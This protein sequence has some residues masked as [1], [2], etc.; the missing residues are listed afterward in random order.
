MYGFVVTTHHNNYELISKCLELLFKNSPLGSHIILYVN[1]TTCPKILN[2]KNEYS[3]NGIINLES[4]EINE[5][6]DESSVLHFEVVYIDNQKRNGGLTGTWN[7]GINYLLNKEC[8]VITLLGHDSFVN[9]SIN[10]MLDLAKK[11][12]LS[13][14][15]KYFGPLCRS[16]KHTG[17]NLWQDSE[18]YTKHKCKYLTGF[19]MTFP[20]NSLLKNVIMRRVSIT[21]KS[22]SGSTENVSTESGS[23]E[24]VS[25][26]SGSTESGSTESGSTESD[27]TFINREFFDAIRFPFAGNE[28]E[29]Y[30]R[31]SKL[32]GEAV[33]CNK[34]IIDHEHARSWIK[35]EEEKNKSDIDNDTYVF[36]RLKIEE[37]DFN[38]ISYVRNNRDVV[39]LKT[40]RLALNHYMSI[41]KHQNRK[42]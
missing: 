29:W 21:R 5:S 26:E 30:T 18:Q 7:Q 19:Y 9:D 3:T 13:S 40:E 39:G 24:N 16:T 8:K 33:I 20:V 23:T 15:L 17:I 6:Y 42:Y 12:Y 27:S 2:I 35:V 11:A 1:E 10:I 14:E 4:E 32:R 38:W 37:I 28:V 25:T 31:F 36:H 41:G 34:C 22:K